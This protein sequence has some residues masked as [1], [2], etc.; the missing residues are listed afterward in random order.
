MRVVP[1]SRA[2]RS[3]GVSG[4]APS[5]AAEGATVAGAGVLGV[6]ADTAAAA[7]TDTAA[8]ASTDAAW[9]ATAE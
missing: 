5:T 9:A 2:A 3:S 1:S 8:A 4:F 6:L 7:D